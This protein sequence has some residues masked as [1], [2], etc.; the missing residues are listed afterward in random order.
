MRVLSF[1]IGIYNMAYCL[2]DANPEDGSVVIKDWQVLNLT[3]TPNCNQCKKRAQNYVNLT[4]HLDANA[5]AY[6]CGVHAKSYASKHY[7]SKQIKKIK[8]AKDLEGLGE[9]LYRQLDSSKIWTE[10][11]DWVL[12]ENQPVLKNPTMK[13]VQMLLYSYFLYKKTLEGVPIENLKFYMA[14]KKLEIKGIEMEKLSQFDKTVY[15]DRKELSKKITLELLKKMED[16]QHIQYLESHD[17]KDDLCD[18]FVQAI[19]HIQ[20][21]FSKD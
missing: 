3:D 18:S 17:K 7:T 5:K 4:N 6:F 14:K 15:K 21:L 16:F 8:D 1:D 2:L 20:T 12:F 13:S 10:T 19:E 11:I 9:N